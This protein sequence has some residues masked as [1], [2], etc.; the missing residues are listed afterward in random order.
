MAADQDRG[1]GYTN[2]ETAL[3][4]ADAVE[5]TTYVTGRGTS[6]EGEAPPGVAARV[7]AGG[8]ANP[9]LWV[10]VA[11]AIVIALVYGIGLFT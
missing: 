11:V 1:P 2:P 3:G 8:G 4:G 9:I 7:P 5:K 10:V 6:P